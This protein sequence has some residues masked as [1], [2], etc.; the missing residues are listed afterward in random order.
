[1]KKYIQHYQWSWTKLFILLSIIFAASFALIAKNIIEQKVFAVDNLILEWIR[2]IANSGLD[3]FFV[4]FT[5]IGEVMFVA[6]A[7]LVLISY[8][9]YKKQH[10]NA[11]TVLLLVGGSIVTN[12][13]FKLIFHRIR[14][15]LWVDLIPE[16]G[17]SFP[18]GHAMLSTSLLAS[19][20]IILWNKPYKWLILCIATILAVIVG[21]SRLYI[22]AHYPSDIIAGWCVVL[23]LTF[24]AAAI[25]NAYHK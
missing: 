13:I 12:T 5:H 2:S 11:L 25:R 3:Q 14:P 16:T 6:I 7:A 21:V 15:D 23:S 20:V 8:Y 1:M 19:I 22:G 10:L 17:F 18:S 4:T 24:A 9:F